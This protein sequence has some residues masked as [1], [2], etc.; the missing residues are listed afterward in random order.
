MGSIAEGDSEKEDASSRTVGVGEGMRAQPSAVTMEARIPRPGN[1]GN[2]PA[3]EGIGEGSRGPLLFLP[4][5][6]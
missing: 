5:F 1:L 4:P 2:L 6:H 3:Q